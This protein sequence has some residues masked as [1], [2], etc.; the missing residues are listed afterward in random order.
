MFHSIQL[1]FALLNRTF[2]LSPHENICTIGLINIHYLYTIYSN[3]RP[4]RQFM[5]NQ[6]TEETNILFFC[7]KYL[8][9][10]RFYVS[11]IHGNSL[12]MCG[13]AHR[14]GN[15][16]NKR[17]LFMNMK[18]VSVSHVLLFIIFILY[19]WAD[20]TLCQTKSKSFGRLVPRNK[21]QRTWLTLTIPW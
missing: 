12:F 1:G 4:L 20:V 14:I 16:I 11:M 2:H 8:Q 18:I 6:S 5:I 13:A 3:I 10:S 7:T 19:H 9:T 21:Q 17:T 15:F